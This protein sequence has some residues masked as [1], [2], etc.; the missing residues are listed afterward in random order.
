ME[1][2]NNKYNNYTQ[3]SSAT[4][5]EGV[6]GNSFASLIGTHKEET[7][8]AYVSYLD[9]YGAFDS[10]SEE[11]KTTFR[12]ILNDD[13][14]TMS[15]IESLSYKQATLFLD[16]IHPPG[17]LSSQEIGKSPLIG[18]TNQIGHALFATRTTNNDTFNEALYR[19][20]KEIDNDDTRRDIL[21]E[22]K[23]NVTQVHFGNQLAASYSYHAYETMRNLWIEDINEMNIDF[24]NFLKNVINLHEEVVNDSKL[25]P[26]MRAQ[27]QKSH[28]GYNIILKHYNDIKTETNGYD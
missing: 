22:V 15:E 21:N 2:T 3:Q 4:K 7:K 5:S 13:E 18:K 26:E 17:N 27:S 19:T 20:A 1:V 8:G 11:N 23:T 10:L 6:K 24:E 16:Y 12:K 28:D 25:Y 14:V 9:Q